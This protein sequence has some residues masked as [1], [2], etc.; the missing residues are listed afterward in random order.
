MNLRSLLTLLCLAVTV[1]ANADQNAQIKKELTHQYD[2]LHR[3]FR[4]RNVTAFAGHYAAGY[5]LT[6]AK[7]EKLDRALVMQGFDREMHSVNVEVLTVTIGTVTVDGVTVLAQIHR[8][9]IATPTH[10]N[11]AN[12]QSSDADE[13]DHW[14]KTDGHWLLVASEQV[15]SSR[16]NSR[17]RRLQ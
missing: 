4:H 7:G 6:T 1:S 12:R 9:M 17:P 13:I 16:I 3:A 11:A 2:L 10:A 8:H 15:S 5:T 14:Q